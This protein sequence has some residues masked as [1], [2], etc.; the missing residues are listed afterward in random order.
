MKKILILLKIFIFS[1]FTFI[2][3][4]LSLYVYAFIT[5]K[6]QINTSKN[7]I[8]YDKNNDDIFSENL[9]NDYVK[10]SDITNFTKN[11]IISI[12]DK[13]FYNHR[14]FD[15]PRILKAMI[16]NI[17][18]GK[19]KQG[20]STISQQYIKNLYL[21]FDKTWERKIEE[22]FLTLELETHYSKNE[23]LEGYLNTIDFGGGN[24]GI[25]EASKY[26]FNK[27][28][29]E[30]TKAEASILVGIPKS[31]NYYNPI[32]NYKN[33]KDRQYSVLKSMVNN[34]YISENEMKKIYNE[35]ISFYGKSDKVELSS[36]YYYKDAVMDEMKNIKQIPKTMLETDELNIYTNL[37][38]NV[39][40]KLEET[41]DTEMKSTSM[42][43]ASIVV[44]PK[45]AKI[46]GLIG[47][48]DYSKS[49]FNRAT[50]SKRQVG[51][52]IKPF[53]YYSALEN[54][55]TPSSTFLSE[56]TT[57]NLGNDMYSPKNANNIYAN[58]NISM[59][60]A[61]SYSDNIYAIKTH[62]F[63]GKDSLSNLAK[64]VRIN[65]SIKEL[66]S[67]A[68]GTTEINM[69]DFSNGYITLAN[70]GKHEQ[71][72]LIEKI[73]N[74][75]GKILYEYKYNTE[76]LLNK[77]YVY[78]LNNLLTN[79]YN[80]K[81]VN[82]TSPTLLSISS[83]INGKYAIKSGS[84]SYDY[85]T[86]GYDSNYLV[87]VWAGNDNDNKIKNSESKITKK[88]WAK[89]MNNINVD[90]KWYE[91][92]SGITGEEINPITGNSDK[93]GVLCFYEKGTEPSY[94]YIDMYEKLSK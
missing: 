69:I 15:Y 12:E 56:R 87:M 83:D 59:L 24:Y 42:Q 38:K 35:K 29:K 23:I 51:S 74:K 92:P 17:K 54:G 55:F 77:K 21:T 72:H 40:K 64:R 66:A 20:A 25:K 58:K 50:K 48:K 33:A 36:V 5:P 13:N 1:F 16:I 86:I 3:V 46:V 79:T 73:T 57:F 44:E 2:I 30:L 6:F 34:R 8:Y 70:E 11:A 47:G 39:Q 18:S 93:N 52:T 84:T 80:Y 76:E 75:K 45:T 67:S 28:P 68:L 37:D 4:Y 27:N 22:A 65:T 7:I 82:Y 90:P 94:N 31:P 62:L 60:A 88:I 10:L 53:I 91:I 43:V 81:M 41:V 89:T 78:I 85:W 9:N 49:Q 71:P 32:F 14:G 19:I 61:I 63:L 26:Y